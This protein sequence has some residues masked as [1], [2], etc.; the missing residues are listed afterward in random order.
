MPEH[1][2]CSI[3]ITYSV[4]SYKNCHFYGLGTKYCPFYS[5]IPYYCCFV[6]LSPELYWEKQSGDQKQ[7]E[8]LLRSLEEYQRQ[9]KSEL[10]APF[11]ILLASFLLLL[12]RKPS[13]TAHSKFL[14]KK[15]CPNTPITHNQPQQVTA[16]PFLQ[17]N[18]HSPFPYS[19]FLC[20]FW[21]RYQSL[22]SQLFSF[23]LSLIPK[24][25]IWYC[26]KLAS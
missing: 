24:T 10:R 8:L 7:L 26:P 18:I 15:I 13:S 9:S 25:Q 4:E 14:T 2:S 23:P 5:L 6:V 19:K 16:S 20:L 21:C 22:A 12:T 11:K 1:G 3:N 17:L